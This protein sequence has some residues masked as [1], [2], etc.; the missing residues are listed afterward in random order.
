M[1]PQLSLPG[2]PDVNAAKSLLA[3]LLNESRLYH[4][5]KTY[6]ELPRHP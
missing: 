5:S 3:N 4:S 1:M 6:K 2:I